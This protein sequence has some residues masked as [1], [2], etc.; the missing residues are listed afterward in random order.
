MTHLF[1]HRRRDPRDAHADQ[2]RV[3]R[4]QLLVVAR[5]P[6]H[7]LRSPRQP[8]SSRTA[9][10]PTSRS[11]PSPTRRSASSSR[12]TAPTP[13]RSGRRTARASRSRR[14][15]PTRRT[16][17][18]NSVIATVPA[19]RR[20]ADRAVGG[21]RRG[22]ADRRLET[23]RPCTS[24]RRQ[25]PTR[26][27]TSSIPDAE[28][29]REGRRRRTRPSTPASRCRRTAR[30]SRRLRAGRD[31]DERGRTSATQ[32]ADRHERADGEL[33]DRHARGRVVEEPGRR[34]DRRRAAQAGRLRSRRRSIRCW[35]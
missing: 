26:I 13:T 32:E 16:S 31:V 1:V 35:S 4:R 25:R 22:S 14:R 21:V 11:S 28:G 20:H 3:H 19:A 27:S 12:R 5:R 8:A 34:D 2:R 17:T 29:D 23:G 30:R 18:R 10:R 24:P 15:W 33:D 9:A 6:Q 7:R